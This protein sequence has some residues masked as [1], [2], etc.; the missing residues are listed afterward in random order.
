MNSSLFQKTT[1]NFETLPYKIQGIFSRR[2]AERSK[3]TV[4]KFLDQW[5][6]AEHLINIFAKTEWK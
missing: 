6:M 2:M 5:L 4:G 3:E 1:T